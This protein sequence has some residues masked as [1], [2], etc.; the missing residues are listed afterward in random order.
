MLGETTRSISDLLAD[1]DDLGERADRDEAEDWLRT[2][3]E[4]RGGEAPAAD[5]RKDCQK[6]GISYD[7]LKR[8]PCERLGVVK[9]KAGMR[10]GWLWSLPSAVTDSAGRG[11]GD[12]REEEE[13]VLQ[14]VCE[15]DECDQTATASALQ[16]GKRWRLCDTHATDPA[17]PL[18][19]GGQTTI[20]ETA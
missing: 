17:L 9:A 15:V 20:G 14:V 8:R 3:L 7:T 12:D 16:D 6:D 18:I 2:Y 4:E 11:D 1:S 10:G 5:I 13:L 19:L